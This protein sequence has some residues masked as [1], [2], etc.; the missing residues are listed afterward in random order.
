MAVT[1][2]AILKYVCSFLWAQ[3][4]VPMI[5]SLINY[6]SN[7]LMKFR[8]VLILYRTKAIVDWL[9]LFIEWQLCC[10]ASCSNSE[11]S[12]NLGVV[13]HLARDNS[14]SVW[15]RYDIQ[16]HQIAAAV[17]LE[18][19]WN[20]LSS[21]LRKQCDTAK[22]KKQPMEVCLRRNEGKFCDF[23]SCPRAHH[24]SNC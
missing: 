9:S 6:Y 4:H 3:T 7:Y 14:R 23:S 5:I 15:S 21:Q 8:I 16:F 19:K 12:A 13:A 11:R 2:S 24:C 22:V 18:P 20:E 17:P 10:V 1:H